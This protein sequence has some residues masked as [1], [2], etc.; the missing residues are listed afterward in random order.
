MPY[1]FPNALPCMLCEYV[2]GRLPAW[3]LDEGPHTV[4]LLNVRQRSRGA[5][6]VA[7]RR[8]V[9][10]LTE[11]DANETDDIFRQVQRASRAVQR[12]FSPDG[13]HAFCNAGRLAGQ[14]EAHVHFQIIPRY[15]GIEYS[16]A[17]SASYDLVPRVERE[18]LASLIRG[19][20]D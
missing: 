8:H 15:Q 13:L 7:P 3:L 6:L 4:A 9:N 14:S 11:L 20:Y 5:L 2:A 12:A 10:L 17:R 1:E 16:F 18:A 19:H